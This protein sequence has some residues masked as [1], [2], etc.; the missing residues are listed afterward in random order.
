MN[1]FTRKNT[2]PRLLITALSSLI[3]ASFGTTSSSSSQLVNNIVSMAASNGYV[4]VADSPSCTV[5]SQEL[6]DPP[7]VTA[8]ADGQ[9]TTQLTA[10]PLDKC[11][12]GYQ[13][14]VK[15]YSD[16]TAAPD[17]RPIGPAYIMRVGENLP[18]ATL[19]I[20]F[21]NALGPVN[22]S[23][24]CMD[25]SSANIDQCTNL[26]T[27]GFHVSPKPGSD[28][29]FLHLPPSNTVSDY[30]FALRPD[31]APGTHWLHAHLHGSTSP[32]V[33]NGM[34]G[35][36]ILKGA[37]DDWLAS[38]FGVTGDRDKIMILQ[39]LSVETDADGNDIPLCGNSAAGIPITN[40]IN[41][42]CLPNITANEGDIHHWRLIQSG[43][44]AT[45]NFRVEDVNGNRLDFIEYARDGI[46]MGSAIQPST[47]LVTLQPGYRSDILFQMPSRSAVCPQTT[48]ECKIYLVDDASEAGDSLYGTPE[49]HNLIASVTINASSQTTPDMPDITN[50]TFDNPYKLIPD[51]ELLTDSNGN[52]V[53]KKVYFANED[54]GDKTVNGQVFNASTPPLP[55]KLGTA[56]L[57]NLWVSETQV[58]SSASHPFHIHVNPFQVT[59]TLSNGQ[60]INYW[61]DTLLVSG[62]KEGGNWKE[63]NAITVRSRYENFD[64][65]FVLHCHNLDH[66]DAGMMMSVEISP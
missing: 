27:H 16:S 49:S 39:Q 26:H 44:F 9:I 63:E 41:G 61:K 60:V 42:Q 54:N 56:T 37:T 35:A 47:N 66:E 19:N 40:A 22:G 3:L 18:P 32:Q 5:F 59:E 14:N 29:V 51:S 11:V 25:H 1:L 21:T 48:G 50:S 43:V 58:N 46:N 6:Q 52:F 33:K 7:S 30:Q 24:D 8:G 65:K 4:E 15:S 38:N 2:G 28:D 31:H 64:G 10:L 36:L 20:G 55:L 57:W 53:T 23:Y 12:N 13:V 34:A 17:S 45:V 62:A